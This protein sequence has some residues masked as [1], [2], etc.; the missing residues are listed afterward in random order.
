MSTKEKI[1]EFIKQSGSKGVQ[2][3]DVARFLGG[4]LEAPKPFLEELIK[5]G[6][7]FKRNDALYWSFVHKDFKGTE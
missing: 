5:D 4:K 7:I 3:Y 1:L 2:N 6:D